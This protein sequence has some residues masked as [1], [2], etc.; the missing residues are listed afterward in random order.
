[1]LRAKQIQQIGYRII[2]VEVGIQICYETKYYCTCLSN[3]AACKIT[4][5]SS[6]HE[7]LRKLAVLVDQVKHGVKD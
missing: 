2:K 6:H 3:N 5:K 7:N 1:M 4:S